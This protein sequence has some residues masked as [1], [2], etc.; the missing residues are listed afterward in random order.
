LV[1]SPTRFR[2]KVENAPDAALLEAH[3]AR[4]QSEQQRELAELDA[5]EFSARAQAAIELAS[6]VIPDF[7]QRAPAIRDFGLSMGFSQQE[8][9]SVVDGRQIV[10]LHLA[11]IAGNML[12]AGIIDTAGRFIGLPEP[13]ADG[14]E[15]SPGRPGTGFGSQPAR[16]AQGQRTLEQSAADI[17]NMSDED[18]SK[19][20]ERELENLL[21]ELEQE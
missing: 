12:R 15:P 13:V 5:Q 4:L 11:S 19:L 10:T 14:G 3:D 1:P 9:A 21:K 17:A 8:M 7:Q 16:G 6:Q 18:F 20:D 2:S